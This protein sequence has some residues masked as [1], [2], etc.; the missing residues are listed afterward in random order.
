MNSRPSWSVEQFIGPCLKITI[1][2]ETKILVTVPGFGS[3]YFNLRSWEA[4]VGVLHLVQSQCRELQ[5]TWARV[6]AAPAK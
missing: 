6:N 1:N 3:H 5:V 4:E 2:K